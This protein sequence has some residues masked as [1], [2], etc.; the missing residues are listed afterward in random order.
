MPGWS[1]GLVNSTLGWE[2]EVS[3]LI[4]NVGQFLHAP[5]DFGQG[6]EEG[7]PEMHLHMSVQI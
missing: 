3:R 4:P 2:S 6:M 1:G 7:K 5:D